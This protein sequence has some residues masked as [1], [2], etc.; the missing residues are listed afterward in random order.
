MEF[1]GF[2]PLVAAIEERLAAGKPFCV[3]IE[4]RCG[5]GKSTLAGY[6]KEKFGCP[7]VRMDDY[8]LPETAKTAARLALPGG[9]ADHERFA[10]EVLPHVGKGAAFGYYRFDNF[11]QKMCETPIVIP[12]A[13][14]VVVEGSYCLYPPGDAAADIRVFL[15]VGMEE[16]LRRIQARSPRVYE[17][18]VR[19]WIPM[20]EAYFEAFGVMEKCDFVFDMSGVGAKFGER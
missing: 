14:L 20:E 10:R 9:N 7:V 13:K 3:F 18:Y 12:A 4:G 6:L 1:E 11:A 16:R 8:F 5:A 19:E 2:A 15:T 17:R